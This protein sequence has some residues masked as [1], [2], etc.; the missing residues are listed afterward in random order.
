[1]QN[2]PKIVNKFSG[3]LCFAAATDLG[4]IV[5]ECDWRNESITYDYST[6][7]ITDVC[8][9]DAT[10]Y[11]VAFSDQYI[12]RFSGGI[13]NETY[14]DTVT[15]ANID[16]IITNKSAAIYILDRTTNT[17]YIYPRT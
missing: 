8:L 5:V 16:K 1:M 17:L 14:I 12:G 4:D 3:N 10:S 6:K 7:F 13:L 9:W 11:L 15:I 2:I